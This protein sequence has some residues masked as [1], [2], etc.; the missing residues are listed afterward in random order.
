MLTILRPVF[1]DKITPPT[2][3]SQSPSIDVVVP[4]NRTPHTRYAGSLALQE[5][6]RRFQVGDLLQETGIRYGQQSDR[7][8]S[9]SFALTLGPLVGADSIRQ[10]AYRFGG[11]TASS[12]DASSGDA[13]SGDASSGDASSDRVPTAEL[14]SDPLLSQMV[15]SAGSPRV[16]DEFTG[17]DRFDWSVFNQ[18][19][20]EA[21]QQ[22]E[23]WSMRSDGILILDDVPLPKPHAREMDYGKPIRD[24]CEK[25]TT[26]GYLAVHLYYHHRSRPGYS[27]G[28]RPWLKTSELEGPLPST[29]EKT[30]RRRA[31][32]G[33]EK[34][35]LDIRLEMIEEID[36]QDW[37]FEAVVMDSWYT[38]RWLLWEL[39]KQGIAYV[40]EASET[41]KFR[42]GEGEEPLDLEQIWERYGAS[43]PPRDREAL[44]YDPKEAVRRDRRIGSLRARAVDA[45][46]PGDQY[47]RVDQPVRLVLVK[48]LHEPREKDEGRR[49]LVTNRR[50]WSVEKILRLFSKRPTIEAVHRRGKQHEG[51]LNFQTE[52]LQALRCHLALCL[53]R[54]TLLR[55]LRAW[56]RAAA[57]YSVRE[58]IE[59]W[60]Q[61]VA[62]MQNAEKGRWTV[63]LRRDHPAWTLLQAPRRSPPVYDN[64]M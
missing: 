36:R 54:G 53:L 47:T 18:R 20:V 62:I 60:I 61:A 28:L 11:G 12:G 34:S 64:F 33:E 7:A 40:G 37:P 32:E 39:T 51:W 58:L 55:L 50:D 46:M 63:A 48:G 19:R 26:Y 17:T 59:H 9:M 31:K 43:M 38:A 27:L 45:T 24:T 10:T 14:E 22:V 41:R 21:L 23:E 6:W 8:P 49:V 42:V 5:V 29:A 30:G 2:P 3:F 52:G 25:R 1:A 35:R 44:G 16:L 13:S 4:S 56:S 57:A 15:S